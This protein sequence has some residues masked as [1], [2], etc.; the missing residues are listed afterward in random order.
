MEGGCTHSVLPCV[1]E[2]WVP[3]ACQKG[4]GAASR[5]NSTS[6]SGGPENGQK[7]TKEA[8]E[9]HL[10]WLRRQVSSLGLVCLQPKSS[11]C[12]EVQGAQ[13]HFYVTSSILFHYPEV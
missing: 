12:F 5:S 1:Q 3:V 9:G 2:K 11:P 13:D 8:L 7:D 4:A 10:Q 6:K